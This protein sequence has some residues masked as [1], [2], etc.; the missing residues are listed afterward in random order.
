M[1][2]SKGLGFLG[3]LM[4]ASA[5]TSAYASPLSNAKSFVNTPVTVT[6]SIPPIPST[7]K[8]TIVDFIDSAHN[9][10]LSFYDSRMRDDAKN[11]LVMAKPSANLSR[12][13][14]LQRYKISSMKLSGFVF[15]HGT[16]IALIV[17][18]NG[19]IYKVHDGSHM[20]MSHDVV[21]DVNEMS[22]KIEILRYVPN[23]FG[24]FKKESTY[25]RI[26]NE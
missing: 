22:K 7:P 18:P 15:W 24:K 8:Y 19:N 26:E 21:T 9:P 23:G 13:P 6:P 25:M 2:K 3:V 20:G 5:C 14:P 1:L 10:F 16:D 4:L 12:L 17:T 11:G